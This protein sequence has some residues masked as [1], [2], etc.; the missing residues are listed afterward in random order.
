[1]P[2]RNLIKTSSAPYH[3]V[4]RSN[5]KFWFH[6]SL[7]DVWK[8]AENSFEKAHSKHPVRLHAFVLMINHYHLLL[9]T[10]DENIDKF[11]YEFNKT[12]SL[13]LRQKTNLVN[14]MFGGRY[15][16]SLIQE[17]TH[18]LHVLKYIYRNPVKAKIA[19]DV[20]DYT[21]STLNSNLGRSSECWNLVS[22]SGYQNYTEFIN[23]LNAANK[24]QDDDLIKNGLNRSKFKIQ[25]DKLTCRSSQI[26][27]NFQSNFSF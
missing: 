13:E 5:H 6:L 18:Y 25:R 10:P 15:K 4:S 14:R 8:I 12:F 3:I 20:R 17:K 2:R 19:N 26:Q 27:L 11:M 23:W 1:M 7:P 9:T 16:W 22:K 21:F 24:P